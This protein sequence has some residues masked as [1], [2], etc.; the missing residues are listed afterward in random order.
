MKQIWQT[1]RGVAG[2]QDDGISLFKMCSLQ[3]KK[4]TLSLLLLWLPES[5]MQRKGGSGGAAWKY[6]NSN[7]TVWKAN[8]A[9]FVLQRAPLLT[10][11]Q[12]NILQSIAGR[13][14]WVSKH[15]RGKAIADG[16]MSAEAQ[17][18]PPLPV[19]SSQP[20]RQAW[21]LYPAHKDAPS[22]A[23]TVHTP[24]TTKT[25]LTEVHSGQR[26]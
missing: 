23:E 4:H 10:A 14:L 24:V 2:A 3:V 11:L 16:L 21:K 5:F 8:T 7:P 18:G 12:H 6:K 9:P 1:L 25:P 15:K 20:S 26:N 17:F 22:L 13:H 19:F